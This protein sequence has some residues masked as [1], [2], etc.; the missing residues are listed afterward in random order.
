MFIIY[1]ISIFLLRFSN[2]NK[3]WVYEKTKNIYCSNSCKFNISSNHPFS[4]KIPTDELVNPF[5]NR[6]KIIHFFFT[7]YNAL[8]EKKLEIIYLMAYDTSNNENIISN[9][10]YY[11]IDCSYGLNGY[12]FIIYKTLKNN[13][14]IQFLFLGLSKNSSIEVE[15]VILSSS[16]IPYQLNSSNSLNSSKNESILKYLEEKEEKTKSQFDLLKEVKIII[17]DIL[18]EMFNTTINI[19]IIEYTFSDTIFIFPFIVTVSYNI[20]FETSLEQ[21]FSPETNKISETKVTNGKIDYHS[22]GLDIKDGK[23]N[24]DN[25]YI[26]F[27]DFY[28]KKIED[29][30]LDISFELKS[31]TLT[32]STNS[33]FNCIVYTFKF[34]DDKN[35]GKIIYEIEIKMELSNKLVEESIQSYQLQ[36]P[37]ISD[38]N[39]KNLLDG[40]ITVIITTSI[41]AA[42]VI[43][44]FLLKYIIIIFN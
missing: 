16:L 18:E 33:L 15:I 30:I 34:F 38:I 27:F 41:T 1:L 31:Y 9:G 23:V 19:N 22:D 21:F 3:D 36:F 40:V 14:F 42:T 25:K 43:G 8:K 28:N 12:E 4:P 24:F 39:L 13:S 10:D 35:V 44:V 7:N 6:N 37:T 26:K 20:N 2:E 11:E 32:I 5:N 17:N 29:L